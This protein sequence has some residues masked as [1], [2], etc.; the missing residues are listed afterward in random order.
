MRRRVASVFFALA[1]L[2]ACGG[3]APE[4]TRFQVPGQVTCR[5]VVPP[6]VPV[7]YATTGATTVEFAVDGEAPGASAGYPASGRAELPFPCDGGR[8]TYSLTATSSDGKETTRRVTVE[9]TP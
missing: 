6:A 4:I 5:G 8:H 1:V 7:E 9:E 2:V 3:P